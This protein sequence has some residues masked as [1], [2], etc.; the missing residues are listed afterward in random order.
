MLLLLLLLLLLSTKCKN[1][2]AREY[3]V[4]FLYSRSV[5]YINCILADREPG[6]H[7]R[8]KIYPSFPTFLSLGPTHSHI[9]YVM[10]ALF[11]RVEELGYEGEHPLIS[12]AKLK[13]KCSCTCTPTFVFIA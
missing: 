2:Q 12:S 11:L 4:Q 1:T 8:D 3:C 13:D 5:T 9:P 6:C 7:D 10:G